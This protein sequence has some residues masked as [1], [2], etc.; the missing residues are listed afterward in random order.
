MQ[1]GW[2]RQTQAV[3]FIL[4]SQSHIIIISGSSRWIRKNLRSSATNVDF[5]E[6]FRLQ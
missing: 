5:Q 4:K 6:V 3:P 1:M 2:L